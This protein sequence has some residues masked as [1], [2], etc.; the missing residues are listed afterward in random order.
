MDD[1]L[2]ELTGQAGAAGPAGS[3]T[4]GAT[5]APAGNPLGALESV[6]GGGGLGSVLGAALGGS[7]ATSAGSTTNLAAVLPSILPA[8]LGLLSRKSA[9]GGTGLHQVLETMQANGLG[10]IASSW[11]GTGPNQAITPAEVEQALGADHLQQLSVDTG[12]PEEQLRD[13]L[14]TILPALVNHATPNGTVPDAAGVQQA[15]G[16]L[17][18]LFG[19]KK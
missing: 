17:E 4:T 15:I 14:A 10:H 11:V 19:A 16:E 12:V 13:R 2:K 9:N 6:L 8:I 3:G 18:A 1:L 5:S 7:G